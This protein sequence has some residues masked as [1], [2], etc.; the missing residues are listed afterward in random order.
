MN[1]DI[2]LANLSLLPLMV[3]ILLSMLSWYL[4]RKQWRF[5]R[6]SIKTTGVLLGYEERIS[7]SSD[8]PDSWVYA[9]IIRYTALD[10]GTREFTDA[11]AS[12]NQR[13]APGDPVRIRYVERGN[14]A[15]V[16][17]FFALY[18]AQLIS[19]LLAIGFILGAF[20]TN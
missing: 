4:W 17:S 10:G 13:Y 15:S 2:S 9:P 5:L 19:T 14:T 8:G 1:I 18:G 20:S 11:L 16:D 7:R 6:E 12:S 3:G